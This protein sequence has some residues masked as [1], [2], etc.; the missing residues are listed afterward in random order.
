MA[1]VI[2]A[3]AGSAVAS[4]NVVNVPNSPP[5]IYFQ[6]V[7]IGEFDAGALRF[8]RVQVMR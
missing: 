2:Y 4:V 1:F 6:D 5:K 3:M 7:Q 8:R